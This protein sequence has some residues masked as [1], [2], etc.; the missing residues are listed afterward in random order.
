[1]PVALRAASIRCEALQQEDIINPFVAENFEWMV[2]SQLMMA[3]S[4]T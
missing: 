2:R 1:M 4:V 3:L